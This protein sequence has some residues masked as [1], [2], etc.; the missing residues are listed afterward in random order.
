VPKGDTLAVAGAG[1]GVQAV[2]LLREGRDSDVVAL[3]EAAKERHSALL[4]G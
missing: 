2:D 4:A 1:V 3:V